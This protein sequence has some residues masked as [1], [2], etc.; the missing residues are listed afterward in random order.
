MD[1]NARDLDGLT[2]AD[3]AEECGHNECAQFLRNYHPPEIVALD[4]SGAKF[5]P[6]GCSSQSMKLLV[7]KHAR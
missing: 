2:P 6:C 3:L 1:P 7:V 5:C 4:V